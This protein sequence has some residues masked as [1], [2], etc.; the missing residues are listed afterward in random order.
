M[1]EVHPVQGGASFNGREEEIFL[2]QAN[3]RWKGRFL[4]PLYRDGC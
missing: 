2:G 1:S 3:P 4:E